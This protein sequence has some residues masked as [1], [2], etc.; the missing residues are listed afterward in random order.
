MPIN[1]RHL[2]I[3]VL[4]FLVG[5]L[6]L[7]Q[8]KE[9]IINVWPEQDKYPLE[10][11]VLILPDYEKSIDLAQALERE[12][13]KSLAEWGE[14]SNSLSRLWIKVEIWPR[15][16]H[17][18]LHKDWFLIFHPYNTRIEGHIF[19]GENEQAF[20]LGA[21]VPYAERT[22]LAPSNMSP[23]VQ[24]ITLPDSGKLTLYAQIE[25]IHS[26]RPP[27]TEIELS[28]PE[29]YERNVTHLRMFSP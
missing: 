4:S 11:H 14:L 5:N 24:K 18:N 22:Y 1:I 16:F 19:Q 17:Q 29:I 10:Q 28:A 8:K 9:G 15:N 6:L 7:A 2:I 21:Y 27:F 20:L 26:S 13:F 23:S 25:N 3:F 12:D